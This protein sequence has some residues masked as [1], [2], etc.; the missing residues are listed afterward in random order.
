MDR[1]DIWW[2][3]LEE[4]SGSS[5]GYRRPILIIQADSFN[6]SKINTI[7]GIVITSNLRLADAPGNI[8]LSSKESGLPK[9]SVINISQIITID[10][11]FLT[12]FVKKIKPSVLNDVENSLKLVLDLD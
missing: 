6:K 1:G 4:P 9:D 11:Q 3:S 2:A 10:K 7:I 8:F 12:E 5:P